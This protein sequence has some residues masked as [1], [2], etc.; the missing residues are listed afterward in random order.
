MYGTE[1]MRKRS[2]NNDVHVNLSEFRTRRTP[3][4]CRL[5]TTVCDN[6]GMHAPT[7]KVCIVFM[8]DPDP[9]LFHALKKVTWARVLGSLS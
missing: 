6:R 8:T 3:G 9:I 7:A 5:V 2:S 1:A 4:P